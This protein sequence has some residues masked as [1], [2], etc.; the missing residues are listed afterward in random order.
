MISL[1]YMEEY[2][3]K[4]LGKSLAGAIKE[5]R[6]DVAIYNLREICSIARDNF[7]PPAEHY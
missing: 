5:S 6:N 7:S 1:R 3:L 4:G 2:F